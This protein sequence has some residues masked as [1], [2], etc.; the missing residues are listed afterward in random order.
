[1]LKGSFQKA[2]SG[3]TFIAGLG[4]PLSLCGHSRADTLNSQQTLAKQLRK[5]LNG[6]L[7]FLD[8]TN[9]SSK[10]RLC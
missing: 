10:A 9:T 3:Q 2:S 1:M 8:V 6:M 5:L 4:A 7:A